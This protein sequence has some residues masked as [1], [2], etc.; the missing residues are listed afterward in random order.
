MPE[1]QRDTFAA[2]LRNHMLAMFGSSPANAD[3]TSIISDRHY[4]R[5]EGLASDAASKGAKLLQPGDPENPDWR[6]LRKFPPTVVVGATQEMAIMQEEIFGPLLAG[7][8]LSRA[9]R[10][11][12][13]HQRP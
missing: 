13:P 5:L 9:Q 4:A 7:D 10:G 11:D 12:Q 1:P 2:Q 8:R 6:R 3:Y